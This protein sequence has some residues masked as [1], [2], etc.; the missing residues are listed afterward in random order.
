MQVP[1]S[2]ICLRHNR[3]VRTSSLG[4]GEKVRGL[5]RRDID[6]CRTYDRR[7][8]SR[9]HTGSIAWISEPAAE[10]NIHDDTEA[11]MRRTSRKICRT[12]A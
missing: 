3:D 4:S 8:A 9:H 7:R 2:S 12:M 5:I 11:K 6:V 10:V 1:K